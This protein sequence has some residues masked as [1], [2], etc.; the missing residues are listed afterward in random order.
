MQEK[1]APVFVIA[2]SNDI[3][4]LPPELLRKGRFD[5]IFFID[6][7][8]LD[9]R[10]E[11]FAIHLLKRNRDPSQFDLLRLARETD[12]FSGAEIEQ[13]VIAGLYDAFEAGRD[14]EDRD[15]LRDVAQSIPLSQTMR[16]QITPLRNWARTHARPASSGASSRR[17]MGTGSPAIA[18]DP[19]NR[20]VQPGER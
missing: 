17:I 6:L 4:L 2:T 7:P 13:A 18:V 5:E 20:T 3:T 15:M 11:I 8:S 19:L 9:E 12:G 10:Q 16:E 14:L 1:T